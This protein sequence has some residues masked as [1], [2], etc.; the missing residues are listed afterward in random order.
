MNVSVFSKIFKL[1]QLQKILEEQEKAAA[2]KQIWIMRT[3]EEAVSHW[4][5][6]F[7]HLDDPNS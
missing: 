5:E 1:W 3:Q 4:N 6:T 7:G 2:E